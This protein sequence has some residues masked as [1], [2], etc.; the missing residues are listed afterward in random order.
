M[1]QKLASTAPIYKDLE[2]MTL[3]MSL[4]QMREALGADDPIIHKL[5]GTESPE[6]LARKVVTGSTLF[7]PKVRRALFEGGAKAVDA[8]TDPMILLVKRVDAEARAVRKTFEDEVEAVEKENGEKIGR[9]RFA[10]YGTTIYPDATAT[11]RLSYGQV[12]GWD[13]AGK[14][15]NPVTT[16]GGA[17]ERA[18]G[19]DPFRLPGRWLGAKS[20]LDLTTF[21]NMATTND[22]IGGNSGSPVINKDAEVVGLI[23]DGN[24]HSLG[25]DY[26]YD[27]ANNRAVAVESTA[28]LTALGRIYSATRVRDEIVAAQKAPGVS[29][30]SD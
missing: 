26:A 17:F 3:A 28:L 6:G 21:F 19:S 22:I 15:V 25:G 14:R 7:D 5:L 2:A 9:A 29:R 10:V 11:L 1:K 24:I 23:F 30:P 16:F 12:K 4:R 8:S 18:T 20:N 27:G 13:E